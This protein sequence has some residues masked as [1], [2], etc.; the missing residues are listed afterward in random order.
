[1]AYTDPATIHDPASST[2]PP[3][4]WGDTVRDDLEWFANDK[5]R[6]RV[7]NSAN[8]THT[9]N[10]AAQVVTFNSE[11][12][13]VGGCHSTSSNTG[14]LTVPSGGGGLYAIG[15]CIGWAANASGIR[16]ASIRVNGSVLI[17]TEETPAFSANSTPKHN[18]YTEW[19]LAAGDYVE[20]L[21]YQSSGGSLN[22]AANSGSPEF[23][24]RW[25][26]NVA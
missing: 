11:R 6:A 8:I 9:T 26:A 19:E 24:F 18:L 4:S 5:P 16:A 25:V 12:Y 22:I 23:W 15:A 14:R 3:A 17:A 13:D 1:M 2:A 10:G 21:A 20:V 7:Y